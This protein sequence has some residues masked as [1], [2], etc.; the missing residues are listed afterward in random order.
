MTS[1]CA[2]QAPIVVVDNY[3]SFTHNIVHALKGEGA[4][5][6]VVMNDQ[7]DAASLVARRPAGFVIS[8][9]PCTPL[10]AGLSLDLVRALLT[11]PRPPPLLGICLGHQAIACAL[12][13]KVVR[14]RRAM[15]GKRT[16][17]RH[18]GRG[19]LADLPQ[20]LVVARYNSLVV[21]EATLPATLQACGW[22]EDGDLMAIRH[23][24]K[25]MAGVQFHPESILSVGCTPLFAAWLSG[26]GLAPCDGTAARA[27]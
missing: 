20:P 23:R 6:D 13:A 17:V 7:A 15:H 2:D 12:G 1:V 21:D 4:S 26:C 8:A 27:G 24:H 25:P 5:C 14:A 10:E 16:Q 19:L 11:T 3:D 22:D 9:G 18:D